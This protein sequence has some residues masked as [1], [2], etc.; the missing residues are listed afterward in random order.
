MGI[1]KSQLTTYKY[2]LYSQFDCSRYF[3]NISLCPDP[4]REYMYWVTPFSPFS[5]H[6]GPSSLLWW[7]FNVEFAIN[8]HQF[9][10]HS[11]S[12]IRLKYWQMN[13][14]HYHHISH[15]QTCTSCYFMQLGRG[16][17]HSWKCLTPEEKN[18]LNFHFPA[19]MWSSTGTHT[20]TH[21]NKKEKAEIELWP[22][23]NILL[24]PFA[25]SFCWCQCLPD[26]QQGTDVKFRTPELLNLQRKA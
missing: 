1:F 2:K 10:I 24:Q 6:L 5:P 21:K 12:W 20:H 13:L 25:L 8:S 15:T 7:S 26:I 19:E 14:F 23:E 16:K 22:Q 17:T 3:A 4:C 11:Y 18:G 9:I